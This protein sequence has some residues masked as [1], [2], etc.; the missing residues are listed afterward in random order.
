[1]DN[2]H[3]AKIN[4]VFDRNTLIRLLGG[5][6][7]RKPSHSVQIKIEKL[8]VK[9]KELINPRLSYRVV[10]VESTNNE[11]VHI[12]GG[13]SFKSL[14]LS[15]TLNNCSEIIYF[16]ATV[17]SSIE[18]ELARLMGK[19]RL[20]DAYI[21]DSMGSVAV[22]NMVEEFHQDMKARYKSEGREVTFRFSPGYPDWPI[23]EQKKLFSSF[24]SLLTG[25]ELTDS[26]LMQPRKSI[27]GVFGVLPPDINSSVASYNPCLECSKEN[28]IV[29]RE[30]ETG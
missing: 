29:R 23:V 3:F 11:F 15:K 27:S 22:E 20:S 10:K 8:E 2:I 5:R 28:C 30:Q 14:K 17:G 19:N 24:D 6:K 21:L 25:V 4:P 12:Q 1:M 9:L 18:K 26:C 13:P 16:I 7:S